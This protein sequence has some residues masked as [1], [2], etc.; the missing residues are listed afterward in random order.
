MLYKIKFYLGPYFKSYSEYYPYNYY[1][2]KYQEFTCNYIFF[3]VQNVISSMEQLGEKPMKI[4]IFLREGET[5][6]LVREEM[7]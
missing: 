7:R 6:I 3:T 2:T 1:E 4:D 5:G